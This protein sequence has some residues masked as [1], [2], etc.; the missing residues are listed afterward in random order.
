[1]VY[2]TVDGPVLWFF[3][4]YHKL[5][6]FAGTSW[7]NQLQVGCRLSWA[8]ITFKWSSDWSLGCWPVLQIKKSHK[9][10]FDVA[11]QSL[12]KHPLN[13]PAVLLAKVYLVGCIPTPLKNMSS[14]LG[15]I[16]P[17]IWNNKIH[18]PNHQPDNYIT[19]DVFPSYKLPFIRDFPWPCSK[20]RISWNIDGIWI[21]CF[22]F[23]PSSPIYGT[24]GIFRPWNWADCKRV[25]RILWWIN[26][27]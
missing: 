6:W 10:L 14:S 16:I 12:H 1:M 9:H 7:N 25:H 13:K 26:V 21:A 4:V 2:C 11:S 23:I 8:L 18:V 5:L 24:V 15:I 19:I 3:P 22:R 20:P 17:N 27:D